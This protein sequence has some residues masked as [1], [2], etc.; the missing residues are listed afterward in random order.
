MKNFWWEVLSLVFQLWSCQQKISSFFNFSNWTFKLQ[1]S[2]MMNTGYNCRYFCWTRDWSFDESWWISSTSFYSYDILYH[3][4]FRRQLTDQRST[5]CFYMGEPTRTEWFV[6]S[7][8]EHYNRF[9]DIFIY[10]DYTNARIKKI[11][12]G[13]Y[14]STLDESFKMTKASF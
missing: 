10:T 7:F 6:D 12:M 3:I 5:D 2:L 1:V 9:D 11:S 14:R 8:S 13:M 4:R